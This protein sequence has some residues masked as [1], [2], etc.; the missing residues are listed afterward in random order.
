LS[1]KIASHK[2]IIVEV[3]ISDFRRFSAKLSVLICVTL[4]EK[5]F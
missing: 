4:R 1:L 5:M 3:L 2:Q